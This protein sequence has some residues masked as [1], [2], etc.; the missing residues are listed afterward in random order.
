MR[1]WQLQEATARLSDVVASAREDGPQ[2]ISVRGGPAVV[3]IAAAEY[4]RLRRRKPSFVELL[5]GSPLVGVDPAIERERTSA[6]RVK[7]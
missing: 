4:E 6:R 2:E 3:V 7:P 1:S 5:R